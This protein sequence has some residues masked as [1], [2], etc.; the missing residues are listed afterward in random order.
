MKK[1]KHARKNNRR[2]A[3]VAVATALAVTVA[4]PALAETPDTADDQAETNKQHAPHED[5]TS[6]GTE[7]AYTAEE[8]A[9]QNAQT[10]QAVQDLV[11][12]NT[13]IAQ[14]NTTID[15]AVGEKIGDRAGRGADARRAGSLQLRVRRGRRE[16]RGS[17]EER[18]C[19]RWQSGHRGGQRGHGRGEPRPDRA[20]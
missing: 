19:V 17:R 11:T 8:A 20:E 6:S 9:A 13:E 2:A 1:A 16:N 5:D 3:S 12:E 7:K 4:V 10:E 18:R 15:Q 14:N